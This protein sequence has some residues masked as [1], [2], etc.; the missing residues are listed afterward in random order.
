MSNNNGNIKKYKIHYNVKNQL[1][2]KGE[3][4]SKKESTSGSSS[5][6]DY[7]ADIA[8][9]WKYRIENDKDLKRGMETDNKTFTKYEDADKWVNKKE[10][11]DKLMK[12]YLK[13][14]SDVKKSGKNIV[15]GVSHFNIRIKKNNENSAN[16]M[17][18]SE[19]TETITESSDSET[20]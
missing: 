19:L 15:F 10:Q 17:E 9:I 2:G 3:K 13:E 18:T 16:I 7:V 11:Q 14:I 1:G 4:K 5:E 20:M 12:Q 6:G 8:F